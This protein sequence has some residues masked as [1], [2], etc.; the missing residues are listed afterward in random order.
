MAILGLL[1]LAI[2]IGALA[3]GLKGRTG[4]AWGAIT[5]VVGAGIWMALV[6]ILA[7][8]EAQGNQEVTAM[9]ANPN[10][11]TARDIMALLVTGGVM[12]LI[13]LSLPSL[14]KPDAS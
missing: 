2:I 3:Q 11:T 1:V 6:S 8:G 4:A 14:K 12:A 7:M 9:M 5:L 10:A 13:V